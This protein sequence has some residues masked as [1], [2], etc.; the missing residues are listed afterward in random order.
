M[1][2]SAFDPTTFLDGTTTE[3]STRRPPIPDG[4]EMP[5]EITD[6]QPKPWASKDQ[7]KSGFKFDVTVKFD[8]TQAP[9]PV[10]QLLEGVSTLTMTDSI[11]L[12]IKDG[13]AIDYAKGKNGA[14]RR[15]REALGMNTAGVSFSPRQMIG[16][17]AKFRIS[18]RTHENEIF[19]Q[20][21]GIS[22]L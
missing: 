21:D 18:H 22:K 14:L 17:M 13:G 2:T 15:Y 4:T 16:R 5:G 7:T 9:L 8:L 12:D 11:M 19:D 6:L 20:I 1:D 10:Q 3:E